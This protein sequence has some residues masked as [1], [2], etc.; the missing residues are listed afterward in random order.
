MAIS[1]QPDFRRLTNAVVAVRGILEKLLRLACSIRERW[2]RCCS[3]FVPGLFKLV[4]HP[5]DARARSH[6][7]STFTLSPLAA[8][9]AFTCLYSLVV[10]IV[11]QIPP[12]LTF[13]TVPHPRRILVPS[14]KLPENIQHSSMA[15]RPRNVPQEVDARWVKYLMKHQAEIADFQGHVAKKRAELD[16]RVNKAR[17]EFD[18]HLEQARRHLLARHLEEERV[19]WSKNG[20]GSR[21]SVT[22][23]PAVRN[24][25]TPRMPQRTATPARGAPASTKKF[26]PSKTPAPSKAPA[27][28]KNPALAKTTAPAKRPVPT[29]TPGPAPALPR[30]EVLPARDTIP[31]IPVQEPARPTKTSCPV[32]QKGIKNEVIDLCSDDGTEP[33]PSKNKSA[34]PEKTATASMLVNTTNS[35]QLNPTEESTVQEPDSPEHT[36]NNS[37]SALPEASLEFFGDLP[38]TQ[39]VSFTADCRLELLMTGTACS[40]PIF[41][42]RR[43]NP[44]KQSL[45]LESRFTPFHSTAEGVS[46]PTRS[47]IAIT[48]LGAS[49]PSD[50]PVRLTR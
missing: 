24:N 43:A 6:H 32:V 5:I 48:I 21:I 39:V 20:P 12:S 49:S 40:N 44:A 45:R 9:I 36:V 15:G 29:W 4:S 33:I 46:W 8:T 7:R 28:V 18:E 25:Q 19:F 42:E 1:E 50:T 30:M 3:P 26:A 2:F 35:Q 27:P 17:T 11:G 13:V 22:P 10:F 37:T 23:A 14:R 16:D 34:P 41:G 31:K 47:T 38:R